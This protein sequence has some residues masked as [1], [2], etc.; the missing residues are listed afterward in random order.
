MSDET[1]QETEEQALA[2]MAGA[3]TAVTLS[4]QLKRKEIEDAYFHARSVGLN[5]A[6]PPWLSNRDLAAVNSAA[7]EHQRALDAAYG[8]ARAPSSKI[9]A[10]AIDLGARENF[11]RAWRQREDRLT[12][13]LLDAYERL[14]RREDELFALTRARCNWWDRRWWRRALDALGGKWWGD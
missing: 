1:G 12:Q 14:R 10:L 9:G 2:R 5:P 11:E 7:A 8:S 13:M 3:R 4:A 6:P